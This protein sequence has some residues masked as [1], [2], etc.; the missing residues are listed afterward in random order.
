MRGRRGPRGEGRHHDGHGND[1]HGPGG[2]GRHGH[3]GRRGRPFD[4]GEMRLMLLSLIAEAP[5]HGYELIKAV[6]E[7]FGGS[8]TPSP[9][10][11][12]PTLAWLDDMGFAAVDADASARKLYR[13]TD[14]GDAWLAANKA[15]LEEMTRR[16]HSY[17]FRRGAPAP[18]LRAMENLKTALRLRMRQGPIDDE[19]AL[20]I[21]DAIDEAAKKVER[22]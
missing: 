10:V 20:K 9:G 15:P 19:T 11:I 4:Y 7:R 17:G 8:Y 18:M 14:A 13:I 21:A 1:G 2:H 6:E 16:I 3:G 12:Y 5:R 22:S